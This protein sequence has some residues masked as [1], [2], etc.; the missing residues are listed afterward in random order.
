LKIPG[1][2]PAIHAVLGG[3]RR[4]LIT[5]RTRGRRVLHG[6]A[7][8]REGYVAGR[9][10]R[11]RTRRVRSIGAARARAAGLDGYGAVAVEPFEA[12]VG[13]SS[14]CARSSAGPLLHLLIL[15]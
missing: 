9:T 1:H 3:K 8:R 11:T 13:N 4:R 12:L 14:Y 10:A 5:E 7:F 6:R 15:T 2:A